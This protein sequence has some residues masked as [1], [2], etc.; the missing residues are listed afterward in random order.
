MVMV[1]VMIVMVVVVVVMGMLSLSHVRPLLG[2]SSGGGN[3]SNSYFIFSLYIIL[4]LIPSIITEE[5][6][7]FRF[8]EGR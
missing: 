7:S 1:M 4:S 2:L 6:M 3:E 8:T 5:G